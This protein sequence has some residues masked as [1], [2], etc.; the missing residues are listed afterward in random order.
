MKKILLS[1]TILSILIITSCGGDDDEPSVNNQITVGDQTFDI[2][3]GGFV[4]LGESEGAS[5]GAFALADANIS[6][7]SQSSFSISTSSTFRIVFNLV[8]L[9][10]S[11]SSG[12]YSE[13]D[14]VNPNAGQVFFVSLIEADGTTYTVDSGTINFSGSSPNFTVSFDLTLNGGTRLTGGYSGSFATN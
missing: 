14:V 1:L 8:S 10:S 9:G 3:N 13:G 5:Q 6:I 7:S 4:D 11:L 12:A 2:S